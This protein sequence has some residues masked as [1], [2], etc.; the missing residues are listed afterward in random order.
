ML[1]LLLLLF[2]S[3]TIAA[4]FVKSDICEFYVTY[5]D[6]TMFEDKRCASMYRPRVMSITKTYRRRF[7]IASYESRDTRLIARNLRNTYARLHGYDVYEPKRS[8]YVTLL[9]VFL[10]SIGR[11]CKVVRCYQYFKPHFLLDLLSNPI[12][13]EKYDYVLWLDSDI[14]IMRCNISLDAFFANNYGALEPDLVFTD[15]R[16]AVNSGAFFMRV[17]SLST[18]KFMRDWIADCATNNYDVWF[19][20]QGILYITLAA[21]LCSPTSVRI[22]NSTHFDGAAISKVLSTF[23]ELHN[24]ECCRSVY[25]V[26]NISVCE[27]HT[28]LL[29]R[30]VDPR[31]GFN[32]YM[33]D[34]VISRSPR[35]LH[36]DYYAEPTF[37][38]FK[39]NS[40]F[41]LHSHYSSD[42]YAKKSD[43]SQCI[44][45]TLDSINSHTTLLK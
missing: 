42:T 39:W 40:S 22:T 17:R 32:A 23:R 34:E 35:S 29:I 18:I 11:V 2:I 14:S 27:P 19:A 28:S 25:E 5:N 36:D 1:L 10:A 4:K 43:C 24:I 45:N 30:H 38:W 20:D 26:T 6:R 37:G 7:L 8:T 33:F 16:R 44:N 13:I 12:V 3:S 41:I 31:H 21:S 9:N 15:G